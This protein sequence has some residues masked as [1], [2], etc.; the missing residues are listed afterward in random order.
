MEGEQFGRWRHRDSIIL[1]NPE[2][3]CTVQKHDLRPIHNNIT[4]PKTHIIIN[5]MHHV[6]ISL[7]TRRYP[8]TAQVPFDANDQAFFQCKVLLRHSRLYDL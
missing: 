8:Q 2:G 6:S 4:T 7:T 5:D 1:C 3:I